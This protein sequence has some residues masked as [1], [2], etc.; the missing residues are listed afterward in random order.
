M[1]AFRRHLSSPGQIERLKKAQ[2]E[3]W[4]ALFAP[5]PPAD[6]ESR[7]ARIGEIHVKIGLPAG[8]YMAGYAFLL[9]KL[10][11]HIAGRHRFSASARTA[12]IDR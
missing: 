2:A 6:Q 3:H 11:P 12:L 7:S 9:K 5:T 8:W 10:L 4:R 1:P